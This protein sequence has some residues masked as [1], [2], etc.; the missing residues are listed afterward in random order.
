MATSFA[1]PR[2][3]SRSLSSIDSHADS[4]P[5]TRPH[6]S[7][8]PGSIDSLLISIMD[9][10]TMPI[11]R[12]D[13]T[14]REA[15]EWNGLRRDP[16]LFVPTG[17][18]LVYLYA[19]GSSQQGP[20]FRI[21]F[22]LLLY[23][24]CRP[25]I[26]MSLLPRLDAVAYHPGSS[27]PPSYKPVD[28]SCAVLYLHAPPNLSREEAFYYHVTTR[29]FFAWLL[30][31]PIVGRDPV[32][33]LLD[34]QARMDVWRDPACDNGGSLY[35]Y[36]REQGYGVFEALEAEMGKQT[37]PETAP[38]TPGESSMFQISV[39][40]HDSRRP[41]RRPSRRE[42][43]TRRIRR[44]FSR[45]RPTSRDRKT[46]HESLRPEPNAAVGLEDDRRNRFESMRNAAPPIVALDAALANLNRPAGSQSRNAGPPPVFN[47][48]KTLKH[49]V[50]WAYNPPTPAELPAAPA[51]KVTK[52]AR[53]CTPDQRS[54][55][56][57]P[58]VRPATPVADISSNH[59]ESSRAG[60]AAAKARP[61][62]VRR[63]RTPS[64][65]DPMTGREICL[66]CGKPRRPREWPEKS[67]VE[68]SREKA[69]HAEASHVE[70][71]REEASR[72]EASHA[73]AS[74]AEASRAEASHAEASHAS[75]EPSAVV[76][77]PPT[78]T[79]SNG[80]STGV[81]L[82]AVPEKTITPPAVIPAR[83]S[84][85][86]QS[87]RRRLA[88]IFSRSG[89]ENPKPRDNIITER[90]DEQTQAQG[91]VQN[92]LEE[93]E[94][95]KPSEKARRHSRRPSWRRSARFFKE[96]IIPDYGN[97]L[98]RD[99][100]KQDKDSSETATPTLSN[101]AN[102]TLSAA[103]GGAGE[104]AP[105][106]TY[107]AT[108][109]PVEL[110]SK[111]LTSPIPPAGVP[112]LEVNYSAGGS[113]SRG[114][115][116]EVERRGQALAAAAAASASTST[117]ASST[118]LSELGNRGGRELPVQ[119]VDIDVDGSGLQVGSSMA[120]FLAELEAA[121]ISEVGG[122]TEHQ[123]KGKEKVVGVDGSNTNLVGV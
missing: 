7:P 106:P 54:R 24:G 32:S 107:G 42:S 39:T 117:S 13:G 112:E 27:T 4:K 65:V 30:G 47:T 33:A 70:A 109:S 5:W 110:P 15:T 53:S 111:L 63:S 50:S 29:N 116:L 76:A 26:E 41:S 102:A 68:A 101:N 6:F 40:P 18:C 36:V 123:V 67:R 83:G 96:I 62:R 104:W 98:L 9:N 52:R 57:T 38:T 3:R 43:L 20:S 35:T 105:R 60:A 61:V 25:L 82:G 69:S 31:V 19:A 77:G 72:A 88:G 92:T 122:D 49:R 37:K 90:P 46:Q 79:Q 80:P 10:P 93:N 48:G 120:M 113:P 94:P 97:G 119:V 75:R 2:R 87:S 73:E 108:S 100:D 56:M 81:K 115:S 86:Q 21:P 85:L 12:W 14:T 34:L 89:R 1:H 16:E 118:K 103:T 23:S 74:H 84:S 95:A 44:K 17:N 55:T 11:H 99:K 64:V 45:S 91:Q 59:A 28:D 51:P 71:S 78:E 22:D 66:C 114:S 58:V 121:G 8:T